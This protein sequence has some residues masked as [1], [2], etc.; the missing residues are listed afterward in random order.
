[1]LN[2]YRREKW[3]E[4]NSAEKKLQA[5][6][7]LSSEELGCRSNGQCHGYKHWQIALLSELD[8]YY[9]CWNKH[10]W[11]IINFSVESSLIVSVDYLFT[12]R[13]LKGDHIR[14]K[15]QH[16]I[17][18]ILTLDVKKKKKKVKYKSQ[19]IHRILRHIYAHIYKQVFTKAGRRGIQLP[20][21]LKKFIPQNDKSRQWW[22]WWWRSQQ[23]CRKTYS[24]CLQEKE[25]FQVVP[26]ASKEPGNTVRM[27]CMSRECVWIACLS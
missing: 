18:L 1:M 2:K 8:R 16:G 11:A 27:T 9:L 5:N 12:F 6:R 13:P 20:L 10:N 19:Y 15:F 14:R 26:K 24:S 25:C 7:K 23:I 21:S 17:W 4:K 3:G 22:C